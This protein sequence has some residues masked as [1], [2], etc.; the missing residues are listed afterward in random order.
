MKKPVFFTD[1]D[2][3]L[4]DTRTYSF[5]AALPAL[6]ILRARRVPLVICSSKTRAEIEHYRAKLGNS[7]PFVSENGGAVFIPRGYFSRETGGHVPCEED[8]KNL[9]R[10]IRLG[11]RYKDLRRAMVELREEGFDVRGFGDMSP[12]EIAA[13]TGLPGTEAVMAGMREFDEPFIFRGDGKMRE[14]LTTAIRTKG[15]NI[16]EGLFFHI[17]GAS[18][19]GRAVSILIDMYREEYGEIVTIA[20]GDS[21]NDLP[22]LRCVEHPVIVEKEGGVYDPRLA[23]EDFEQAEGAGPE[24]WNR[25]VMKLLGEIER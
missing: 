10:I 3:T 8:A 19:K 5:D 12:G 15:F 11:A 6:D 13:T 24:G 4:L 20:L 7:D 16:T 9:Y 1:L 25:A 21:P 14:K 22:M 23:M 2:G 18:D 17:L